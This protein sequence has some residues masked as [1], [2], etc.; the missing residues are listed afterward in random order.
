MRRLCSTAAPA[1]IAAAVLALGSAAAPART[2]HG[3]RSLRPRLVVAP[4][5]LGPARAIAPGDRIE[6]LA[7]LRRR[8]RGRFTA[9]YFRA[10]ATAGSTLPG[11][12]LAIDRCTRK[13][14]R[15]GA[16]YTCPGRRF[17][18]LAGRPLLGRARLKR[19]GRRG[20][21]TANLRLVITLPAGADNT[22]QGR[23][24]NAVYSFVGVAARR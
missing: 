14:R 1:V 11:L 9:V 23:S 3:A 16:R 4:S 2:G 20:W 8:G 10:R 15:H 6:R 13:W 12:R 19:L 22:L 24:L 18:V 21:R 5:K 17:L 7:R